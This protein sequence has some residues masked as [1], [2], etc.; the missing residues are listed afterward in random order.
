MLS[1]KVVARLGRRCGDDV[2][3][4]WSMLGFEGISALGKRSD[5]VCAWFRAE[6]EFGA[7]WTSVGPAEKENK[8]YTGYC[9][10]WRSMFTGRR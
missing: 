5:E 8:T 9:M 10:K 1:N 7:E 4:S 6:Y 2:D 3:A